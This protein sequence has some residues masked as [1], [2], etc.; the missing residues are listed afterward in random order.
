MCTFSR[1]IVRTP[2]RS[3]VAGLS[4][5]QVEKP[6][7]EIALEQHQAYTEALEYCGLTVTCLDPLEE[8]PDSVFVEDTAIIV[9]D[10]AVLTNPGAASRNGEVAAILPV[11]KDLFAHVHQI[12]A[13]GILDGG[14]V[15]ITDKY[16]FI[17]HSQRTNPEGATQ[18]FKILEQQGLSGQLIPVSGLLHLKTGITWLG[19]KQYIATGSHLTQSQFS[20][21]SVLPV[22]DSCAGAANCIAINDKILMSA[23]FPQ[24]KQQLDQLGR[25]VVEVD[26]SEYAKIDGGLTCLS[27]RF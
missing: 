27:L 25:Q 8:Y 16:C 9:N 14:D 2:G 15:M 10:Q 24:V 18:L 20:P 23:G 22:E 12:N 11:L 1:A 21:F 19:A 26:I 6:I 4:Q 7:Y 13:P 3:L 17:G 5:S